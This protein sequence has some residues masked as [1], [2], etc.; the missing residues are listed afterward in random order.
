MQLKV[1]TGWS[2]SRLPGGR[3]IRDP[4]A[5]QDFLNALAEVESTPTPAFE[6][7]IEDDIIL[8]TVAEAGELRRRTQPC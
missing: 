5:L 3:T 1:Q 4:T 7:V 2:N 6:V 8:N